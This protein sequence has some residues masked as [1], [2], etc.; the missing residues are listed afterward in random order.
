MK[1]IYRYQVPKFHGND[2]VEMELPTEFQPVCIKF[3]GDQLNLWVA[4][5]TDALELKPTRLHFVGTGRPLPEADEDDYGTRFSYIETIMVES[6]FSADPFVWH[7]FLEQQL[8]AEEVERI[9][10][11]EEAR[12]MLARLQAEGPEGDSDFLNAMMAGVA[13]GEDEDEEDIDE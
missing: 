6:G 9:K 12:A 1:T 4:V 2:V 5:D 10:K 8:P 13:S 7:I 3:K 11:M